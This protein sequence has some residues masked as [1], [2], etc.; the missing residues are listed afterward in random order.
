VPVTLERCNSPNDVLHR[1]VRAGLPQLREALDE[2]GRDLPAHVLGELEG[3]ITCGDPTEGFAWLHCEECDHHRIVPF[4]CKGRGFCPSCG[5]RRMTERA[6]RWVDELIPRVAVRQWV[7]TVPWPRRLLLA[8]NPKLA[9]GVLKVAL[10]EIQRWLRQRTGQGTGQGG[11]VTV[12]QRFASALNLNL[13][14]HALVLDGLYT[15]DPDTGAVRWHRAPSPTDEEVAALVERI[16]ERAEAFLARHGHGLHDELDEDPD[17]AQVVIHCST[18]GRRHRG[19][20][21]RSP[22]AQGTPGPAAGGAGLR[23]AS[24]VCGL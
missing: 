8:R 12:V 3:F 9:R 24:E 5:G 13:H 15:E 10:R 1:V 14:F 20:Q 23:A 6:A 7:I 2:A 22:W 16:A 4:T 19:S 21:R 17:D 18:T 11:S